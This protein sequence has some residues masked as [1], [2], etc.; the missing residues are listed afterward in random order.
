MVQEENRPLYLPSGR[1]HWIGSLCRSYLGF[2]YA[3]QEWRA[4]RARLVALEQQGGSFLLYSPQAPDGLPG[5]DPAPRA[6]PPAAPQAAAAAAPRSPS[7]ASQEQHPPI[8]TAS[9]EAP[10]QA[11]SSQT[12]ERTRG[13]AAGKRPSTNDYGEDKVYQCF[14]HVFC[15]SLL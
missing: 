10:P 14:G 1:L 4:F 6:A 15:V 5:N 12:T 13:R 11:S 8:L 2:W 3:V 9:E 7:P